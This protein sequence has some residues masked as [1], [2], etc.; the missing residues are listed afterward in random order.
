VKRAYEA[1]AAAAAALDSP[2]AASTSY[3]ATSDPADGT[4]DYEAPFYLESAGSAGREVAA[5]SSSSY[6]G[7]GGGQSGGGGGGGV[8]EGLRAVVRDFGRARAKDPGG[9][10]MKDEQVRT[11]LV[12]CRVVL[13]PLP[14]QII[15]TNTSPQ[16]IRSNSWCARSPALASCTL[17]ATQRRR[18]CRPT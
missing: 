18:G 15:T 2:L 6:G 9:K 5:A 3:P 10:E 11:R 8:F 13:S 14:P 1:F 7:G 16:T 4:A 12:L 17:W